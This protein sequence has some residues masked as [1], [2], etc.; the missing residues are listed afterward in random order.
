MIKQSFD[1]N[2]SVLTFATNDQRYLKFAFN[3]ARSILLFNDIDIYIVTNVET[4]IPN[5]IINNVFLLPAQTAHAKLGVGMKLY[6]DTYLQTQHSLFIDSDCLCFGSLKPIFTACAGKDIAVV[7]NIV[8]SASWCGDEQAEI[9]KDNFGIDKLIRFNG[10]LYYMQKTPGTEQIFDKARAIADKYDDY[11]FARINGKWMNEEGPLS[12]AMMLHSQQPI[13]DNGTYMTDLFTDIQPD[14][15]N[16]LKGVSTLSNPAPLS[17]RHREWYPEKTYSPI[18]I[19]FGGGNLKTYRYI[20]QSVLL[21]LNSI[22]IPDRLSI[23]ITDVI[24]K[25]PVKGIKWLLSVFRN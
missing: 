10:G 3:C 19:H 21:K 23:L 11:H 13:A 6:M 12:I 8:A 24:I 18:I 15:L 5:D 22:G 16:V 9:I 2:Y 14:K 25:I 17:P 1:K 7:G 20:S 4:A